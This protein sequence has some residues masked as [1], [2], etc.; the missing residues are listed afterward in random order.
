[1][2]YNNKNIS[3]K[4]LNIKTMNWNPIVIDLGCYWGCT[5]AVSACVHLIIWSWDVHST[6][7]PLESFKRCTY[8]VKSEFN[9]K[10]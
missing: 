2:N 6:G 10:I 5:L 4:S 1:M 3:Y 9:I 8:Y 7:F